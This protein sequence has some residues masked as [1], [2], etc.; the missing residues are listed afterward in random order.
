VL[1]VDKNLITVLLSGTLSK[2]IL[3]IKGLKVCAV[4]GKS[5]CN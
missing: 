4:H 2:L 3:V 5:S 1:I